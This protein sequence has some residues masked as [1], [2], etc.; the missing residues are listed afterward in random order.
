MKK[1]LLSL[2]CL[3]S[4]E[5]GVYSLD[6]SLRLNPA[7]VIP[8]NSID[9]GIGAFAQAD[10]NLFGFLTA[11][12]EGGYTMLSSSGLDDNI[13]TAAGGIGV[14]AYTFPLSR[15][16]LGA[17]GAFG[18][19]SFSTKL[20][21][22]VKS[23]SDLYY[24][25]YGEVGFR[26]S[27]SVTLSANGGW[28]SYLVHNKAP[29][30]QGPFAGISLK[31][32]ATVGSKGSSAFN[33]DVL[34][35]EPVYPLYYNA[36]KNNSFANLILKNNEG[37][38]IRNVKVSIRAGRYTS[39]TYE[40]ASYSMIRKNGTVDIP[41]TAAFSDSL[42]KFTENGKISGEIIVDY[43]L[44]NTKKQS[45]ENI[46]I[47]V[48]NR[49]AFVW[50]DDS[51]LASFISSEVPEV[52]DY[53]SYV[54]GVAES[55]F[56]SAMNRNLQTSAAMLEGLRAAG[57]K[58]NED[59]I[60]PYKTFH[61]GYDLDSV[62][63]P[64][65]T[66]N[67]L[68]GDL[69]DIGILLCS[70]LESVGVKTAYMTLDED[71]VVLVSTGIKPG[72]EG[73]HFSNTTG[74]LVDDDAVYIPLSMAAFEKGFTASRNAGAEKIAL[75]KDGKIETN[76]YVVVQEAWESYP[77]AVL[78]GTGSKLE[79]P[80]KSD[81]QKALKSA[82]DEYV[83]NDLEIVI[84]NARKSGNS[85]KLGL[86]LTRAG[87][88]SEAKREFQKLNT[89]SSINNFANILMIEGDYEQARSNYEKVLAR[90]PNNYA[91]LSG[92]EQANIKLGL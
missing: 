84:A 66:M 72:S 85:N 80:A 36:Y 26:F 77:G 58:Y 13:N 25:G 21:N 75:V 22:T 39:A 92:L 83:K 49:N 16:Y 23:A 89:D 9:L 12:V 70:C 11:G 32:N 48:Y 54:Y 81:I 52:Q 27:P 1:F 18:I 87:R 63:Y 42:L 59:K 20:E 67:Y 34:Q 82:I 86:A 71:F 51:A 41:L 38:E 8:T 37:A 69:D 53:A 15:L 44:L 7:V 76:G 55:N 40:A 90:N 35:D 60:T 14:G 47:D 30:A 46:I 2:A 68:S 5:V 64:L 28:V 73:N 62:Q 50:G 29:L 88:Y 78:T 91:A 17:G 43:E 31:I 56:L 65:Q 74:L 3:F 33:I 24:R 10:V 45:V 79:K 6:L 19:Y 57:I 4:L 61:K